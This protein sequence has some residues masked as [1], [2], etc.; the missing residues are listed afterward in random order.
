M[1]V[2]KKYQ[3]IDV[4]IPSEFSRN[5]IE[6]FKNIPLSQLSQRMNEVL[7]EHEVFVICQSGMRSAKA[8]Q[9]L[10]KTG[11]DHVTNIKGGIGSYRG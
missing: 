6:G 8:C 10:K 3:F 7:P 4:R 1:L 9:L 11:F 5:H 2:N